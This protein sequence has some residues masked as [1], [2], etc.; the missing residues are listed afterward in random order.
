[1]RAEDAS[2]I[3]LTRAYRTRMAEQRA[4]RTALDTHVAAK[5]VL[6]QVIEEQPADR[7]LEKRDAALVSGRGPGIFAL[8][9]VAHER[10]GVRRQQLLEIAFDRGFGAASYEAG[11]VFEHPH[12][13]VSQRAHLDVDGAG[14]RP[15]GHQEYGHLVVARA[16]ATQQSGCLLVRLRIVTAQSP[17]DEDAV[18]GGIGY[19]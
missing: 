16:Q 1:M 17:V 18:Q 4:E 12:E 8:T 3:A 14:N 2:C 15:V 19:D 6:S 5:D 11:G 9:V 13:L 10:R 7:R